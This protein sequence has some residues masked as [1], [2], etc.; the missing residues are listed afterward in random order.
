MATAE[1]M[2]LADAAPL[3]EQHTTSAAPTLTFTAPAGAIA[4]D[5]VTF[6][7]GYLHH[8]VV[9]KRDKDEAWLRF[10]HT[11][12]NAFNVQEMLDVLSYAERFGCFAQGVK[13]WWQ[14]ER[15]LTEAKR[16]VTED[17]QWG[18]FS[19]VHGEVA[20]RVFA[21]DMSYEHL[22]KW[23]DATRHLVTQHKQ[24]PLEPEDLDK[25]LLLQR[26]L[27]TEDALSD[28]GEQQIGIGMGKFH[29]KP[30]P[31][32]PMPTKP[33]PTMKKRRRCEANLHPV[34]QYANTL[35]VGPKT[36]F[37]RPFAMILNG[38]HDI[39]VPT[40]DDDFIPNFFDMIDAYGDPGSEKAWKAWQKSV[41]SVTP[42]SSYEERLRD[43]G[44]GMGGLKLFYM[45]GR[46]AA[47]YGVLDYLH[48]D[49]DS[50]SE[51]GHT[52]DEDS[53]NGSEDASEDDSDDDSEG[54]SGDGSEDDSEEDSEDD[55][56][57]PDY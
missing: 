57:D 28:T 27:A 15:L 16:M 2:V 14:V 17:E 51:N 21:S 38:E 9:D 25:E 32:K 53:G 8:S 18:H 12:K 29:G 7:R 44:N 1:P 20:R 19:R 6:S 23:F 13:D 55:S 42:R 26:L 52:T 4:V 40:L 11:F 54:D 36:P 30:V 37:K 35:F 22:S 3:A 41:H 50:E 49:E 46:A 48:D 56:D 34:I 24:K 33:M 47:E 5:A 39:K 31:T 45:T 10:N 43:K